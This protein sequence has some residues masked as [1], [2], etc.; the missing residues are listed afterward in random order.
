M[1]TVLPPKRERDFDKITVF[2]KNTEKVASGH[3]FWDQIWLKID[4]G[5][6]QKRQKWRKK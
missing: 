3:L 6:A 1:K 2:K 5:A 4:A